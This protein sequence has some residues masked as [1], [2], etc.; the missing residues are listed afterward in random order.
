[1]SGRAIGI[2]IGGT[3]IAAGVVH[4]ATGQVDQAIR[5]PTPVNRDG[6]AV[7]AACVALATELDGTG[8]LKAGIAV[9]ELVSCA[10]E[11]QS[12]YQFDWLDMDVAWAFN[13]RPISIASD[14]RAAARAEAC[15][16]RGRG[17]AACCTSRSAPASVQRSC[18]TVRRGRA[19]GGMR[20]C[21]LRVTSPPSIRTLVRWCGRCW[22][23]GRRDR[24]S[25]SATNSQ[26]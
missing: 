2:D 25:S 11:I 12:A 17:P 3:K 8:E 26:G 1:M 24:P 4:L 6:E 22:K 15:S 9:P 10:G 23:S 18:L 13:H 16:G 20:S 5:M 7:L 21:S 19:R 14:V